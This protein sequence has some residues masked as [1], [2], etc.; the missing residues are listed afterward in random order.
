VVSLAG[1]TL[2][3][4]SR[5]KLQA[6]SQWPRVIRLQRHDQTWRIMSIDGQGD[7]SD[8]TRRWVEAAPDSTPAPAPADSARAVTPGKVPV[9]ALD[10]YTRATAYEELDSLQKASD[11]YREALRSYPQYTEALEGL[12]KLGIRQR[13]ND[14]TKHLEGRNLAGLLQLYP[15]MPQKD[16]LA[17]KRLLENPSVTKITAVPQ[18]VSVE[19]TGQLEARVR[20]TLAYS[21]TVRPS[22]VQTSVNRYE[23]TFKLVRGA[24]LI[25]S[26]NGQL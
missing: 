1:T 22:G 16:Q 8:P 25:T 13:L 7:S 2:V 18:N 11:A 4:D 26:M 17:W 6:E 21:M 3:L 19:L 12:T 10:A 15:E 5:Q 20:Y 23:A 24:W 9:E 14:W